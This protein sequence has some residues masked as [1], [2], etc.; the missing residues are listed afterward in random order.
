MIVLALKSL[1]MIRTLAYHSLPKINAISAKV[2]LVLL[3]RVKTPTIA[4]ANTLQPSIPA[5]VPRQTAN[6]AVLNVP[7]VLFH[8]PPAIHTRPKTNAFRSIL[9]H[10][11]PHVFGALRELVLMAAV[12][13]AVQNV[14]A[15]I[16]LRIRRSARV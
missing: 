12:E 3:N 9:L 1:R 5:I 15:T 16:Q 6:G 10:L 14:N 13:P 4:N 8:V 11:A 2:S 7:P